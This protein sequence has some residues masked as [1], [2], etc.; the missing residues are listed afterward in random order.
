V[1][2]HADGRLER[3]RA[4][5]L[6]SAEGAHSLVRT[7]LDL[8]FAGRTLPSDYALGD[9]HI[10]GDLPATDLHIFSSEHGLLAM[11]PIGDRHF[12][13]IASDPLSK[14]SKDTEPAI[15]ELQALYDQRSHIPARLRDLV[16]SSWF[17][18]NSR[19]VS[20][21]KCGRLLLGGDSAHIHSPAAGQG[22]NTGIQDMINLGWKLALVMKGRAPAA[23]LDTYEQDRLPVMR[24]IL[25]RTEGL[26]DLVGSENPLVRNLFNHFGPWIGGAGLVQAGATSQ[27]SQIA[28]GYRDSQLSESHARRGELH[29]GDRL[30]DIRVR[31]RGEGSWTE[32][33]LHAVLD[34]SRFALLVASPGEAPPPRPDL[35]DTLRP[36]ADLIDR[37]EI[38]AAPDAGGQARFEAA[39]GHSAGIYLVRPDGYVGFV[40]GEHGAAE[41]VQVEHLKAWCHRWLSGAERRGG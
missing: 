14:P 30:P 29:A 35:A 40:S 27:I 12:R 19:M 17:R 13:L 25:S 8:R 23:L 34:P 41:P 33:S 38:A 16:W 5:W 2:R 3:T 37:V 7:T 6:I 28:L 39:F 20:Q 4:P 26:T 11:I 32:K 31:A 15:E 36:W 24:K 9:L 1:L 18:I 10:D 21:L 22:M